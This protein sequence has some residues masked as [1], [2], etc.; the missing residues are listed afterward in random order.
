MP[1]KAPEEEKEVLKAKSL[2]VSVDMRASE[3]P[4]GPASL[5]LTAGLESQISFNVDEETEKRIPLMGYFKSLVDAN[6]ECAI[7]SLKLVDPATTFDL[8]QPGI[9]SLSKTNELVINQPSE[10][11]EQ[12]HTKYDPANPPK[13]FKYAVGIQASNAVK[14]GSIVKSLTVAFKDSCGDAAGQTIT[15]KVDKEFG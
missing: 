6:E 9:F 5:V 13:A 15:L 7:S 1:Y 3:D 8:D 11:M 14:Q 2:L 10:M 12:K 4:C